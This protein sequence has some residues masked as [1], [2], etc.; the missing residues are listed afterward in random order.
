MADLQP[1]PTPLV[2][3]WRRFVQN[4][5]P[6]LIFA[7]GLLLTL[8]L[9]E[10][11]SQV[12]N[13]IGVA[14]ASFVD[15]SSGATGIL[16]PPGHGEWRQ[17]QTIKE[18]EIIGGIRLAQLGV[19]KAQIETI[20][21]EKEKVLAD[22]KAAQSKFE[23][24]MRREQDDQW[25]NIVRL[26]WR[27]EE[28]KQDTYDRRTRIASAIAQMKTLNATLNYNELS[29]QRGGAISEQEVVQSRLQ[30]KELEALVERERAAIEISKQNYVREYRVL[31]RI[32]GGLDSQSRER[33]A[34]I[35]ANISDIVAPFEKQLAVHDAQAKEVYAAMESAVIRAPVSGVIMEIY[36]V[37]GQSVQPGDPVIRIARE[38]PDHIISYVRRRQRIRPVANM[39]VK[40]R[41][42]YTGSR[43]IDAKVVEVGTH[44]LEIPLQH[45]HDPARVEWGLP[46]KIAIPDSL[47][48]L[49]PGEPVDIVFPSRGRSSSGSGTVTTERSAEGI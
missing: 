28:I 38:T 34:E 2:Y 24:D 26:Y 20:E 47:R 4:I 3:R 29:R 18:G 11:Q 36:K 48:M 32:K 44:V 19:F 37:P 41:S 33:A 49:R 7:F 6:F 35:E 31:E 46:V 16:M 1:I 45:L 39:A 12:G 22:R 30:V 23:F 25:F 9:W 14:E 15:V 5:V 40:L 13:A 17:Y 27:V 42:P 43:P 21:R 10:R 8:W